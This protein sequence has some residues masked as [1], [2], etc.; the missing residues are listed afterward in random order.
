MSVMFKQ[1][2]TRKVKSFLRDENGVALVEFALFLPLFVLAFFVIVEFSRTFFSYQG[3]LAGVRDATRYLARVAPA[4]LCQG[5][6]GEDDGNGG[7]TNPGDF[8][9][10]DGTTG[11]AT[12]AATTIIRRNMDNETGIDL[13]D[14]VLLTNVVTTYECVITT[15]GQ[16]RQDNVPLVRVAATFDVLFPLA[17]IL[18]LNGLEERLKITRTVIDTSR[19]FGA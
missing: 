15:P 6:V 2:P 10:I 18:E 19:G 11:A 1:M 14:Q 8:L 9:V 5:A 12:A 4:G 16:Y 17:G 3:A 7:T 13:P